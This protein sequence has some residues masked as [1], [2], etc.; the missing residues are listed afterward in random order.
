MNEGAEVDCACAT[1]R[2]I[3]FNVSSSDA[4]TSTSLQLKHVACQVSEAYGYASP[5]IKT[6]AGYIPIV[7]VH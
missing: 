7:Y 6:G 2:P 5:Q 4:A 3:G 1:Y